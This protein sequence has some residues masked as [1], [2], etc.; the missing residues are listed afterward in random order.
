MEHQIPRYPK[1]I[2]PGLLGRMHSRYGN[3]DK[4]AAILGPCLQGAAGLVASGVAKVERDEDGT[5]MVLCGSYIAIGPSGSGKSTLFRRATNPIKTREAKQRERLH[6]ARYICQAQRHTADGKIGALRTEIGKAFMGGEDSSSHEEKLLDVIRNAPKE[7][8]D[9]ALMQSNV[10]G[11]ALLRQL[12]RNPISGLITAEGNQVLDKLRAEDFSAINSALDGEPMALNRVGTGVIPIAT[13]ILTVLLT[14]QNGNFKKFLARDG[15]LF[16]T[17]G[18]GPRC[19]C[20]VVPEN[21]VGTENII[22]DSEADQEMNQDYADR[23]HDL[24]DDMVE[25]VR[26]G[27]EGMDVKKISLQAKARLVEFRRQ[28]SALQRSDRYPGCSGFISKMVDHVARMSA[29]WHVFEGREGDISSEYVE[30]AI[31]LV[32]Y[33]LDV[34]RLLHAKPEAARSSVREAQLLLDILYELH[35]RERPPTRAELQNLAFNEGIST[36]ARFGNALGL[37]GADRKVQLTRSGR[38]HIVLPS[39]VRSSPCR[40]VSQPNLASDRFTD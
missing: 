6:E 34:H 18:W 31:E 12:A 11:Q 21:W 1:H 24:L 15:E 20:S 27:M 3:T 36:A 23:C 4:D 39:Q 37:L 25:N 40:L 5:P 2:I 16:N 28:T 19:L 33:H 35:R 13:P 7:V 17:S 26:T 9:S 10:T 22:P 8:A 14:T 32:H 30:G 38:I 29:I